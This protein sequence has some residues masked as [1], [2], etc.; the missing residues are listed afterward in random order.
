MDV[1][2]LANACGM[3]VRFIAYGGIIVSIRVPD[4]DGVLADV[5]PGYDSLDDYRR[6]G[7]FFG[8]IIGRYAN[9]I[10]QSRFTL[11]GVEYALTENEGENHLHGGPGG[12]HRATW[13]VAPFEDPSARVVLSHR[14]DAGDQGFPGTLDARVTYALTDDNEL[15]V[16]YCATTD[17]PTPV[18]L[19]Q[20]A[21]FNL[22]G[23]DA[24][25]VLD[26][27][28]T[29]NASHFLPV[30]ASLIP[31]GPKRSVA[32]TPFDFRMARR[33]GERLDQSDEQLVIGHGYDHNFVLDRRD[34]GEPVFAAR[35]HEP[36]SGRVLEIFTT[37]PGIQF[38][39][40]SGV[41][42]DRAGKGRHVYARNAA[43]ALEPQHFPDSPN[44]P[45]FPST[46]LR[47]GE[48]YRSRTV[49]RFSTSS[50]RPSPPRGN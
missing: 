13:R 46:I 10:A 48:E 12:F 19:T 8:A 2:T 21:Y 15:I 31:V 41:G 26:H 16:D 11:D 25:D 14:S 42:G 30:D 35:V 33:I 49:Y 37:E 9:R 36:R 29:L 4:R 7:R 6:D 40:G 39:S 44:R 17:A 47:A 23:H 28:L 34:D 50:D 22:A 5:T 38:Y 3:E 45:D 20:H 18:N 24:G 43:F 27:E 32:G 1:F